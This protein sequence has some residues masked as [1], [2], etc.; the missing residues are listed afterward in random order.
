MKHIKKNKGITLI[1]LVITIVIFFTFDSGQCARTN[2]G[3]AVLWGMQLIYLLINFKNE[4]KIEKFIMEFVIC[5]FIFNSFML[6][7]NSAWHTAS[8]TV[9]KNDGYTFKTVIEKYERETGKKITNFAYV[10]DLDVSQYAV[11]I[12]KM[13]SLTERAL[14]CPWSIRQSLNYYTGRELKEVQFPYNILFDKIKISNY[15]GFC[16]DEIYFMDNTMYIVVY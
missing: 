2:W 8:N 1:A 6:L 7:Q 10:Y 9:D 16:E 14:A 11:G 3:F 13:G 15:D 4:K 12:K 5:S